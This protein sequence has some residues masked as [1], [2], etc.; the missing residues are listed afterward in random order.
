MVAAD[1]VGVVL[2]GQAEGHIHREAQLEVL[3]RAV[4]DVELRENGGYAG[5]PVVRGAGDRHQA[6]GGTGIHVEAEPRERGRT[7]GGHAI[8]LHV[9][10]DVGAAQREL[11]A[12]VLGH[13]RGIEEQRADVVAPRAD[14]GEGIAL[15]TRALLAELEAGGL[16]LGS[17]G[18][19]GDEG[20]GREGEAG[21]V[22]HGRMA[23]NPGDPGVVAVASRFRRGKMDHDTKS[24]QTCNH[25]REPTLRKDR[26]L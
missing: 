12:V 26:D 16:G 22:G 6:G 9:E 17:K 25:S 18:A 15:G 11:P 19:G 14:T 8:E 24:M 21:T 20:Q 13:H 1:P 3:A 7:G 10:A 23:P 2:G 4:H 5:V